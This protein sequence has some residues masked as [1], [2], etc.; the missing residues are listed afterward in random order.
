MKNKMIN[1]GICDAREVTEESFAGFDSVQVNAGI[2]I[3]SPRAKELMNRYPVRLNTAMVLEVPDGQEVSVKILNGKA[4]IGPGDDGTGIFLIV[5][6]RLTVGDGSLEAVKSY[7]RILVN[8]RLLMPEGY[9]GR[10]P[11]LSVNGSTEYYPDGAT[12]LKGDTAGSRKAPGKGPPLHRPEDRRRGEP[13]GG[14][15]LPL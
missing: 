5:N 13:P 7:Y 1:A 3:T 11:D 12:L 14:A 8:G 2:L 6:G 15:G 4:A 10:V 9:R